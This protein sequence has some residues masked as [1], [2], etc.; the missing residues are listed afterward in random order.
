M[1]AVI[2]LIQNQSNRRSM[3]HLNFPF[4][5]P[6]LEVCPDRPFQPSLMFASKAG[7]HPSEAPF[8]PAR[9]KRCGFITNI[10]KLQS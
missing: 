3:V 8:V 9:D 2:Q 10:C 1:T 5:I 4:S 6:W 7:V